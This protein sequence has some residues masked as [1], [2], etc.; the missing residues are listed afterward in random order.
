MGLE[1]TKDMKTK[2]SVRIHHPTLRN[3]VFTIEQQSR[4][5][6]EPFPCPTCHAY[7]TFKTFHLNLNGNG[8]VCVSTEVY[9]LFKDEGILEDLTATKQVVPAPTRIQMGGMGESMIDNSPFIIISRENGP[10]NIPGILQIPLNSVPP[11]TERFRRE[12]DGTWTDLFDRR[13]D[14]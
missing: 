1:I 11:P 5:Y 4:V 10:V 12:E 3:C 6:P 14:G 7:H 2:R 9:Q 8:D 13:N